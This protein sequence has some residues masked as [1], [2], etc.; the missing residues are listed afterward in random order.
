MSNVGPR[1]ILPRKMLYK[2]F[3]LILFG[4]FIHLIAGS[5][6][7]GSYCQ[8]PSD[9][10]ADLVCFSTRQLCISPKS[11][12]ESC[13]VDYECQYGLECTNDFC[14]AESN[15]MTTTDNSTTSKTRTVV[16][17]T[18]IT[19]VLILSAISALLYVFCNGLKCM[20][21]SPHSSN[22]HKRK[23]P[24]FMS[25]KFEISNSTLKSDEI[26]EDVAI[27]MG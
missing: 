15:S 1:T 22:F 20:K 27:K 6:S 3:I 21:I 16:I 19:I 24:K 7:L 23:S 8:A 5:G 26:W 25:D 13:A 14:T 17:A 12:G 2:H 11:Q 9:C 18:S 4:F 10:D